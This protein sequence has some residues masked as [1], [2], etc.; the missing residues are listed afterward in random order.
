MKD[1]IVGDCESCGKTD[2]I[3]TM[4]GLCPSC[5]DKMLQREQEQENQFER[6]RGN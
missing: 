6:F 2:S 5:H 3:N 1:Y 4:S